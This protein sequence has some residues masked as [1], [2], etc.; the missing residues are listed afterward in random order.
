MVGDGADCQNN[1]SAY[2]KGGGASIAGDSITIFGKATDEN[3][4]YI[5]AECDRYAIFEETYKYMAENDDVII[6]NP[7]AEIPCQI[8]LERQ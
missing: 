8:R 5:V 2:F 7:D 3:F 4:D 1:Y 6:L